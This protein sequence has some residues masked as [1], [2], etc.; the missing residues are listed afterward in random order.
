MSSLFNDIHLH[1]NSGFIQPLITNSRNEKDRATKLLGGRS[2]SGTTTI[3]F[4]GSDGTLSTLTGEE[5]LSNKTLEDCKK[6]NG[7]VFNSLYYTYASAPSDTNK[8]HELF[9]QVQTTYST[10]LKTTIV[11]MYATIS[12]STWLVYTEIKSV[13]IDKDGSGKVGSDLLTIKTNTPGIGKVSSQS[14]SK[15][16]DTFYFNYTLV[17]GSETQVDININYQ[18][19]SQN[20][21]I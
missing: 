9:S 6:F 14:I 21:V 3:T 20:D 11:Q 2:T 12:T 10:P 15:T 1:A 16:D 18:I 7:W 5:T 19:L 4:P 8:S 17:D 13:F